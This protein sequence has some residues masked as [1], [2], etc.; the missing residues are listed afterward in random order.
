MPSPL[1]SCDFAFFERLRQLVLFL[2][3]LSS[4]PRAV[5]R[6][7]AAVGGFLRGGG[8]FGL[9]TFFG[10][11]IAAVGDWQPAVFQ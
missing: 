4:S 2:G 5:L 3:R 10:E 11:G 8:L 1:Q 7:D 9:R 6:S